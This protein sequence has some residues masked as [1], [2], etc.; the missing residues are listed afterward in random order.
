MNS[1]EIARLANARTTS[2]GWIARCPAHDDRLPSLSIREGRGGRTV[3]HCHAGCDAGAIV[4][5]LGLS[6][7]DLFAEQ[8]LASRR[9]RKAR[10]MTADDIETELQD[11]LQRIIDHESEEF[12]FD[13]AT[14][15]RHRNQARSIVERR[16]SVCL[17]RESPPWWEVEPHCVDPMWPACVDQALVVAAARRGIGPEALRAAIGDLPKTQERVLAYARRLMGSTCKEPASSWSCA[18]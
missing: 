1:L 11:E 2:N 9:M 4:L 16:F 3:L 12:D 7:A 14:L 8:S 18:M 10:H 17:K 15:T 5:A 13:V 6:L